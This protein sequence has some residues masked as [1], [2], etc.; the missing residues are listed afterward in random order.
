MNKAIAPLKTILQNFA[1]FQV[2]NIFSEIICEHNL[3]F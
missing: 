3:I 1:F 2:S